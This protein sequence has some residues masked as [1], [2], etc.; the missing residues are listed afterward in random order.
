MAGGAGG[1]GRRRAGQGTSG[2]LALHAGRLRHL[3]E[4]LEVPR[5]LPP[6]PEVVAPP[7]EGLAVV[8]P[9]P[10]GVR[11]EELLERF[12]ALV[13][14]RA[15]MR[16]REEG[17]LLEAG[18]QVLVDVLGYA[19][20]R[21][22]PFSARGG[23]SLELAPMEELPGFCEALVGRPV[24]SS[25]EL[26][27]ELPSDYAVPALAGQR[28]HFLVDVR[29][30]WQVERPGSATEGLLEALGRGGTYEEVMESL[31]EELEEERADALHTRAREL[32][33]EAL[34]ER[35]APPPLPPAVVDEE[36]RRQWLRVEAPLLQEK[37]FDAEEL[38][39]ALEG[40]LTDGPT[41]T[42]AER[43]L[44]QALVLGT[45]ARRDGVTLTEERLAE[46]LTG[47]AV[48]LG[49]E[50]TALLAALHEGGPE[51]HERV[52]D[53]AWQLVLMDH[54]LARAQVHFEGAEEQ[55]GGT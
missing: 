53:V 28:A 11:E 19:Q 38:R 6:L 49:A 26:E 9:A 14:E 40:W 18:D 37:G 42:Q 44:Q 52:R 13:R 23:L 36:V 24:G 31:L 39:E 35:A 29:A 50:P 21:L 25:A 4:R 2:E 3:V 33:L 8:V 22:I 10:E 46:V 1:S 48:Q 54:V 7:L 5:R 41:R 15:P 45:I 51:A 55:A 20:G 32:V 12:A 43:R 30:A 27:L 17:E 47:L 16:E 34:L